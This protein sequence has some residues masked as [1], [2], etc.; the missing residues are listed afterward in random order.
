MDEQSRKVIKKRLASD[1]AFYSLDEGAAAQMSLPQSPHISG[2]LPRAISAS[3]V[4]ST[5]GTGFLSV[6]EKHA[7]TRSEYMVYTPLRVDRDRCKNSQKSYI[8]PARI[9][10]PLFLLAEC[11]S[12]WCQKITDPAGP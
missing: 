11:I 1:S 9:D 5:P 3:G 8:T 12:R 10:V 7:H 4:L 6:P 2:A